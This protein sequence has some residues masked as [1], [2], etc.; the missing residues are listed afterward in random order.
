[1]TRPIARRF[2]HRSFQPKWAPAPLLKQSQRSFPPL[3]FPRQTDSLCP[4][5]VTEVRSQI[6]SG[7][8]D[9]KVLID[10]NPGEIRASIEEEDGRIRRERAVH[11]VALVAHARAP[12]HGQGGR[13][14]R[15]R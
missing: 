7:D 4:R 13:V 3:G 15:W 5:C 11:P 12:G 9:W 6:L 10:G 14:T 2:P 8:V 1:M